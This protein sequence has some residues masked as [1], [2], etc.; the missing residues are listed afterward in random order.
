MLYNYLKIGLRNLLRQ[1]G[2]TVLNVMG[3]ALGIASVLLIYRMVTYE[4]SFNKAFANSDRI[5]RVVTTEV[6]ADGEK[7]YTRG[8]PLSAM[9]A[10]KTTVPQFAAMA[11]I[12]ESWPTVIVPNMT[13]GAALKKFNMGRN[14]ISFFVE[15]EF[16]QIFDFQW[17]AGDKNSVLKA[18]NTIVLN[19]EMAEKCFDS[20]EKAMGQTVLI[21]NEPMVVEGVIQTLP[22]N[23]DFP[24]Q[25]LI[26]YATLLSDKKKYEYTED[27]GNTSSNDQLFGLLQSADAMNAANTLVA[28]V[29]KLEYATAGSGQ[30]LSKSHHLQPLSELHYDD[31]FGTSATP[32][33]AKS[34]LWILSFIGIL[35]LA[36]AC[37][38]FINLST[39]MAMRRAKEIGVRKSLGGSRATLFGQFM[40][41][42]ALVVFFSVILGAFIAGVTSPLLKYISDVPADLPFLSQVNVLLFLSGLAVVMT[43]FSGFYPSLV[44]A[45]FNPV[46]ALK[47]DVSS[48]SMGGVSLRKGLV[49]LQFTIA[50]AL[51]VGTI[52]TLSQ[53]NYLQ[54]MDLG[55]KKDLIY[56]FG[57]SGDSISQSK[58]D[59]F[60]QRLLQIPGVESATFGN[61][62][63]SS[64]ST[65]ATNFAI[66]RGTEDQKV[67]TS[68][69]FCDAD[70]QKTYGL[71]LVAGRWLAPS[72]TMREFVVNMTLLKKSG[73]TNPEEAL[74]KELRLGRNKWCKV[75]GV[76]KDFHSHSAHN[77]LEAISITSSKKRFYSAGVKIEPK[78]MVATTAAIQ[79]VFDDTYPEQVFD[80]TYFD[81]S[82]ADFYT[83]ENR[84]SDTCKTFAF[85]AIIISCLGLFGLATHAAQQRKKEIGVRKVLG[86]SVASVIGLLA[87]DFL[88]LVLIAIVFS[89][90]IAWYG[91][92]NWLSEF[93]YRVDMEWWMFAAA[94]LSAMAIAFMTVSFQSLKAAMMNPVKSL[95]SE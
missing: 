77:E 52:I 8:M 67:N 87:K 46:R 56:T 48:G 36:M 68:L 5:V 45:G 27:W 21:D 22:I 55:F 74:Q 37:F 26:S 4:L 29:G 13:G 16:C 31:R 73:I 33:V 19:K 3:L 92:K 86:A 6:G 1:R 18:P 72:D 65:W 2:F 95:R 85:L 60:K 70:Y 89:V 94:G 39:A 75:V 47:N 41:E 34:R 66:G 91:M 57:I 7:Y 58:L 51:I 71:E 76:V 24:I 20:F 49:V 63:P 14:K 42:T 10:V 12:K 61:D 30:A 11:K 84:F 50:Q 80:A 25:V 44:L 43:A 17:L 9:A 81:A 15:P 54:N 64:G 69:K 35:V 59:G 79:R 90:P 38:N 23:C 88:K 32:V 78:N 82:I 28:E 62:Q 40:S 53:M 83:S 93:V